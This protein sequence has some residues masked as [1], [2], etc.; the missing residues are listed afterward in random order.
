MITGDLKS[1]VDKIWNSFWTGGV[2][3]P[4]TVNEQLT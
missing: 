3:N 4:L 2:A 1:Q